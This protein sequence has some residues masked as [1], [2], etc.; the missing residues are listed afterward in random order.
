MKYGTLTCADGFIK[1]DIY[2]KDV[3]LM[4][5]FGIFI[6]QGNS[7]FLE[8]KMIFLFKQL[9]VPSWDWSLAFGDSKVKRIELT[10]TNWKNVSTLLALNLDIIFVQYDEE[11]SK[12]CHECQV[13]PRRTLVVSFH[14]LKLLVIDSNRHLEPRLMGF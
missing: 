6:L 5:C 9:V 7:N 1:V 12:D 4:V 2:S 8:F 10:T 11:T 14:E 3:M 13:T